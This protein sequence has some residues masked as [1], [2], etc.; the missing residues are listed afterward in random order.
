M[1]M[2]REII[3]LVNKTDKNIEH[4]TWTA[5]HMKSPQKHWWMVTRS[6]KMQS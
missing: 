5:K 6:A 2:F 4:F 1:K 3:N